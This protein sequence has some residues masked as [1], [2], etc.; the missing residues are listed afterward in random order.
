MI[1]KPALGKELPGLN[2][3]LIA[4]IADAD[5]AAGCL[6]VQRLTQRGCSAGL[7]QVPPENAGVV[8]SLL[9]WQNFL[10]Q[11]SAIASNQC[12]FK[13]ARQLAP[14]YQEQGGTLVIVQNTGGT[15]GLETG[16]PALAW[17]A[18][19]SG[20][21]KTAACEW[22]A[23]TVRVV[24][25]ARHSHLIEPLIERL[26]TELFEGGGT[27]Q[28]IGLPADGRRI[29]LALKEDQQAGETRA[30]ISQQSVLLVSGGARGVTAACLIELAR[31]FQPRIALLG[32]TSLTA[33]EPDVCKSAKTE[34]E[35]KA[36]LVQWAQSHKNKLNLPE[37]QRQARQILASREV[38][39]TLQALR[40]AGSVAEYFVGD[41]QNVQQLQT[42][43]TDIHQKWGSITGIIHGA[44]VLAD[45][46]IKDKT[47][48]QFALVFNTK[49]KG[50]QALLA[51]TANEPLRVI[52]LFSSVAGRFGNAGQCDYAM[53]NE[54]L[55]KVAQ[56]EQRRRGSNCIVKSMNWGPWEGGMVS[57]A[58]K[59]HFR[60]LNINLLPLDAGAQL[61]VQEL[62]HLAPKQTEVI[63]GGAISAPAVP[64]RIT[65]VF[66]VSEATH[67]YL[68]DHSIKEAPVV[69]MCLALEWFMR[70]AKQNYPGYTLSSC[71]DLKVL[72]AIRLNHF[73]QGHVFYVEC[74][75]KTQ[76]Q[77]KYLQLQLRSQE[78]VLHYTARIPLIT[79]EIAPFKPFLP[80]EAE[81][82]WPWT[83]PQAYQ[84]QVIFH[85]PAFQV[86]QAVS[87]L[88]GQGCQGVVT[89]VRAMA[90]IDPSWLTE[91]LSLD[92][93]M[94]DGGLQMVWL[95]FCTVKG[96][97]LPMS[98]KR[99][100]LYEPGLVTEPI[101]VVIQVESYN[102]IHCIINAEY[103]LANGKPIAK[104]ERLEGIVMP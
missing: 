77:N 20:L 43:V 67:H 33:S 70:T 57:A 65:A 34:A 82:A 47:D 96:P 4:V 102:D 99:F 14:R 94:L 16:E 41:V 37:I 76:Q 17:T 75:Q 58:L 36:A 51:A 11:D 31:Q 90:K 69:P 52:G 81:R 74:E 7:Y 22:P 91:K 80:P 83:I 103:S 46:L 63:F 45:K 89:G 54:I 71:E 68:Q 38:E 28:E 79:G 78:G 86:I 95:W 23:A 18:G 88:S 19:S 1:E 12:N 64:Q 53:A 72:K 48:E 101:N 8:I 21:I 5:D 104:I 3:G 92:V 13:I 35:L 98:M 55:N 87:H 29:T 73:K 26:V 40:D 32:R 59:E 10:D 44:G 56:S 97:I 66:N 24:D 6:L 60:Q 50:L 85:G 27:E 9:A 61:F 49:V 2:S 100:I 25:L 42:V 15:F 39:A 30:V 93:A 62:T 84:Q